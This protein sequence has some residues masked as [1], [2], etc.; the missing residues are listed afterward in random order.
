MARVSEIEAGGRNVLAF[1][2]MLAVSEGT[3][4]GRQPTK[5]NGY[6]VLAC[7]ATGC[8]TRCS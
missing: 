6:D 3:D 8:T 2:D 7:T 4:D 5:D 1:L